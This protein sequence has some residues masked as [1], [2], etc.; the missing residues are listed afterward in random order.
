MESNGEFFAKE[1]IEKHIPRLTD[2]AVGKNTILPTSEETKTGLS[3]TEDDDVRNWQPNV[4]RVE[5]ERNENNGS[6]SKSERTFGQLLKS[7]IPKFVKK[8]NDGVIDADHHMAEKND[9]GYNHKIIREWNDM[10][11]DQKNEINQLLRQK[12]EQQFNTALTRVSDFDVAINNGEHGINKDFILTESGK[13]IAIY[14]ML[15]Y[16]FRYL[17]HDIGF[18][19]TSANGL[20]QALIK[21]PELWLR[22]KHKISNLIKNVNNENKIQESGS[23]TLSLSYVDT[24]DS[25]NFKRN[26]FGIN[27]GV[28]NYDSVIYGFDQIKTGTLI[29]ADA[30]DAGLSVNSEDDFLPRLFRYKDTV[31]SV[32]K[33]ITKIGNYGEHN[34]VG[35]NRYNENGNSRLPDFLISYDGK[36]NEDTKHHAE[37]FNIPIISIN[38][39]CY[40]NSVA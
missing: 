39:K 26:T 4:M 2:E 33:I 32:P 6:N 20:S 37:F 17:K 5:N 10:S 13:K 8:E 35:I 38:T 7:F 27:L 40:L 28:F 14:N 22:E 25:N 3:G 15:G 29:D 19:S 24:S 30:N 1:Y 12:I 31:D 36:I 21:N 34:E 9:Y 18:R 23:Q 11:Q 16:G